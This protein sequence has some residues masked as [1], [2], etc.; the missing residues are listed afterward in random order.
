MSLPQFSASARSDLFEIHDYIA[1]GNVSAAAKFID[2]LESKC[3]FLAQDPLAGTARD[4]L[5]PSLRC[6][7][8]GN[9]VI[10]FKPRDDGVFISRVLHGAR[11]THSLAFD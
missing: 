6:F 5:A 1:R 8:V 3:R 10:F 7:S 4:D 9:F 11:D 2:K